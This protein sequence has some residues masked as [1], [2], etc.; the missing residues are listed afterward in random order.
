M[1]SVLVY[2]S[3]D[4]SQPGGVERVV[5]G[6]VS[7]YRHGGMVVHELGRNDCPIHVYSNWRRRLSIAKLLTLLLRIRPNVVNVH[8]VT[9]ATIYF[10]LFKRMLGY[11]LVLS[12]HGS[13][14]LLGIPRSLEN[15]KSAAK[16][17]SIVLSADVITVVS[18]H[19]RSTLEQIPGINPHR[20]HVVPNGIDPDFWC[21]SHRPRSQGLKMLSAGRLE[22]VKG[23]D[24]LISAF[25]DVAHA[26]PD[27]RLVVAGQGS[28]RQ[29]LERQV[30]D[31]GLSD[32]VVF[33]GILDRWQLRDAYRDADLFVLPSRSEGLPLALLE[34][35]ATGLPFV[36]A[37]V[38]G[39]SEI[40]TQQSGC[41]VPAED[42]QALGRMLVHALTQ[43]DLRE[44]GCA[45]RQRAMDFSARA[46][47]LKYLELVS[48][49]G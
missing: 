28:Q 4:S 27:A 12:F 15:P 46:S 38:G 30:A 48:A 25:T 22:P 40:A 26:V 16:I 5:S 20:I 7:T 21:P 43:C 11:R 47:D 36:A 23:F 10:T 1:D 8:F 17:K 45:A 34:A 33:T 31:A 29:D 35:M 37:D 24:L 42:V 9:N 39:V 44:A 3:V 41:C 2:T 18:Q 19:M 6:L 14:A 32:R 13:D 49:S